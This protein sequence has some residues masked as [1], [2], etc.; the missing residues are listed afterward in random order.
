MA[1]ESL[2]GVD[3]G[4]KDSPTKPV[5]SRM[6]ARQ[7]RKI[8]PSAF[9]SASVYDR[10]FGV[11]PSIFGYYSRLVCSR[12]PP[13]PFSN[14]RRVK[15][16]ASICWRRILPPPPPFP[17]LRSLLPL[18]SGKHFAYDVPLSRVTTISPHPGIVERKKQ[19]ADRRFPVDGTLQL[20]FKVDGEVS[21]DR[22][23]KLRFCLG[24]S[25]FFFF[26]SS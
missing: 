7:P 6:L 18:D 23:A 25:S 21:I 4:E 22:K 11:P 3:R 12:A 17:R 5:T 24:E 15:T 9:I 13:L 14:T 1:P 16:E 19:G 2:Y 26:F 20:V 8:E 10:A